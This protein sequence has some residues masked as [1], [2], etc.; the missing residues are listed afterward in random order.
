MILRIHD[1]IRL[2]IPLQAVFC[3]LNVLA[4]KWKI[5]RWFS[6]LLNTVP[7]KRR[8]LADP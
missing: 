4:I 1:C 5:T 6:V 7:G 8:D 3:L 2:L